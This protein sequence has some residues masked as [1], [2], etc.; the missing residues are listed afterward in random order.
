MGFKI[1]DAVSNR[2]WGDV[3]K[4]QIWQHLGRR[5]PMEKPGQLRLSVR[6]TPW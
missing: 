4:S 2:S 3:D 6:S 5:L 1:S